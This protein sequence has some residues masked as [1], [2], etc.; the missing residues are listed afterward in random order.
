MRRR[1]AEVRHFL[2]PDGG[3]GAGVGH[4]GGWQEIDEFLKSR[5]VRIG[6]PRLGQTTGG[7]HAPGSNHYKGL[8]RDYGDM[9]SDCRAVVR[10]MWPLRDRLLELYYAPT[11][12]WYPRNVGDHGD[13]VH[14]AIKAGVTLPYGGQPARRK[15]TMFMAWQGG[16]VILYMGG[17][18]G[19]WG[20]SPDSCDK[21]IK[22]G[23][24][25]F[26]QPGDDRDLFHMFPDAHSVVTQR[27]AGAAARVDAL[28]GHEEPD[29]DAV[30]DAIVQAQN[31][32]A[33]GC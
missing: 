21:L 31:E 8:A 4:P 20:L 30:L 32:M 29:T 24:P 10:E 7:K 22:A 15:T 5:G 19:S 18:R 26:G 11:G 33:P 2:T 3:N 9:D 13:H 17:V 1:E 23:V 25:I 14:V 6:P 16:G 12:T 28:K 27:G